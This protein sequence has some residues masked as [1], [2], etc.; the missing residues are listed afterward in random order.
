M[1]AVTVGTMQM[2]SPALDLIVPYTIMLPATEIVGPYPVLLQLHGYHDNHTAWLQKSNLVLYVERLPLIVVL[3]NGQN[4]L[5]ADVTPREKY[6]T[7]I[8]N[9]LWNHVHQMFPVRQDRW[10][11]G[12]LSMGGFGA[13]RLGLKYP[14]K[15]CS[16]YAHSSVISY[17]EFFKSDEVIKS[18]VR[19][20]DTAIRADL[21]C[22]K[23]AEKLDLARL[24]RL[25]FDCGVDDGLIGQNRR[26]HAHLTELKLPHDYQEH[27]GAHT[28]D[29]WDKYIQTALRQHAEV[30]NIMVTIA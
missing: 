13:L 21:D 14:D 25:G 10:A 28:W 18:G 30:L 1:F 19:L 5:W 26:F 15:F 23:L 3:P 24:P 16:I 7:F 12:G 4:S 9:D 17:D 20:P 2:F 8:V 6:E 22:Y 27:P 29:Y 11:I